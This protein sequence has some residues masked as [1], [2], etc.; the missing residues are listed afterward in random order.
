MKQ[1]TEVERQL[2]RVNL[3]LAQ[4]AL[5]SLDRMVLPE[6]IRTGDLDV[7]QERIKHWLDENKGR[8]TI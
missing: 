3:E 8:W 1:M 4:M 7:A 6:Q 5:N 2:W